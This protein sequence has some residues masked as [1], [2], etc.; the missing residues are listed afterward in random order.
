VRY[1]TVGAMAISCGRFITPH[2]RKRFGV[3]NAW[4]EYSFARMIGSRTSPNSETKSLRSP[5]VFEW[6]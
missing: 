4:R 3:S 1:S 2:T 6:T 5:S